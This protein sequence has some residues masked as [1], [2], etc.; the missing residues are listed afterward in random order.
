[1]RIFPGPLL[2]RAVCPRGRRPRTRGPGACCH[3]VLSGRARGARC[4]HLACSGTVLALKLAPEGRITILNWARTHDR[5]IMRRRVH[6]A[7]VDHVDVSGHQLHERPRES[8]LT[9]EVHGQVRGYPSAEARSFQS[10]GQT[11]PQKPAITTPHDATGAARMQL[12]DRNWKVCTQ[13]VPAGAAI[14]P[15]TRTDFGAVKLEEDC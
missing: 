8:R 10:L 1:M 7:R 14:T 4:R 6:R 3:G 15:N 5:R 13:N 11:S 2:S 9:T 12:S